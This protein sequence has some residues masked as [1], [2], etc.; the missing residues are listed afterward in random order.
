[1]LERAPDVLEA[2]DDAGRTPLLTAAAIGNITIVELLIERGA[3]VNASDN[4]GRSALH[5][6]AGKLNRHSSGR[7]IAQLAA[8]GVS[9]CHL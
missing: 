7:L 1:L 8:V 2:V 5:Y 9:P 3:N 6:A 4:D